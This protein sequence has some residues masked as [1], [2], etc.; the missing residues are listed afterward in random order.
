MSPTLE[1]WLPRWPA[2][3]AVAFLVLLGLGWPLLWALL[4]SVSPHARGIPWLPEIVLFVLPLVLV[5]V[6]QL[7]TYLLFRRSGRGALPESPCL[8]TGSVLGTFHW[9]TFAEAPGHRW[10]TVQPRLAAEIRAR[11]PEELPVVGMELTF[12]HGEAF[13]WAAHLRALGMN[14][15]AWGLASFL[16][17]LWPLLGGLGGGIGM[18]FVESPMN[19]GPAIVAVLSVLAIG[20]GAVLFSTPVVVLL[21]TV[22]GPGMHVG[23][24]LWSRWLNRGQ[25]Q[26]VTWNGRVLRTYEGGQLAFDDATELELIHDARGTVLVV[27]SGARTL[28]IRGEYQYLHP[29][30]QTLQARAPVQAGGEEELEQALRHVRSAA[31]EGQPSRG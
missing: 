26:R 19:S 17:L 29:L 24:L 21:L 12:G 7:P 27:T 6:V 22:V 16:W 18:L 8:Q 5:A 10:W 31:R 20:V 4:L 15:V 1:R 23:W 11:P 2:L 3:L 14:T 9:F 28:Q 25:S 13:P 30:L